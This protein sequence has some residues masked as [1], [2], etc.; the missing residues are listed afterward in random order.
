MQN[1]R[2]QP[3]PNRCG[4]WELPDGVVPANWWQ[5]KANR[6]VL[7]QEE[8]RL[9]MELFWH[10]VTDEPFFRGVGSNSCDREILAFLDLIMSLS[11]Y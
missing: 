11:I 2:V 9:V 7:L 5:S 8:G 3:L 6:G 10:T 1:H 4:L